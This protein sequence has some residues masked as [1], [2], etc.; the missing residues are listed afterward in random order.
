MHNRPHILV[1]LMLAGAA[2][3]QSTNLPPG[4]RRVDPGL[5]DVGPLEGV[6]RVDLRRELRQ[7]RGF[8]SVYRLE[9]P[10][11]MGAPGSTSSTFFRVDG[12]LT[13]VFPQSFYTP[14]SE[15]QIPIIPPGTKFYIGKL[16]ESVVGTPA[17]RERSPLQVDLSV[18]MR[19]PDP[20]PPRPQAQE[21]QPAA[22]GTSIWDDENFRQRTVARLLDRAAAAEPPR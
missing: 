14:T 18:P 22:V 15:G 7:E 6:S 20:Q 17:P 13:A 9:L 3:A 19:V 12:G 16:P 21:T 4:A 5:G 1:F 10:K 8:D 2:Q 11:P